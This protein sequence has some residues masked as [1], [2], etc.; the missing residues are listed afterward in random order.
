MSDFIE[1]EQEEVQPDLS[2]WEELILRELYDKPQ[3]LIHT[4][5]KGKKKAC[6]TM[7]F[8]AGKKL[9]RQGLCYVVHDMKKLR[10]IIMRTDDWKLPDWA[11]YLLETDNDERKDS[12]PGVF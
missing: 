9:Q 6:Y 8:A 4:I 7:L 2:I 12:I 11:E 3:F 1:E 5:C 10:N